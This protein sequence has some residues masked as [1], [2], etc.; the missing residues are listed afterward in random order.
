MIINNINKND[1][2]NSN[3]GKSKKFNNMS[4][5]QI[6][7]LGSNNRIRM[8]STEKNLQNSIVFLRTHLNYSNKRKYIKKC[9]FF[10]TRVTDK[11]LIFSLNERVCDNYYDLP[12]FSI[13]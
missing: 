7:T 10:N 11:I 3:K 6:Q 9:F 8:T 2:S 1:S 13:I 5:S 12:Y 4:S